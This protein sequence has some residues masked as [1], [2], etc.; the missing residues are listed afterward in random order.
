MID[1]G[2]DSSASLQTLRFFSVAEIE[3]AQTLVH[4]LGP[5]IETQP[6]FLLQFFLY[7]REGGF[8][9]LAEDQ[10]VDPFAAKF[11]ERT[12]RGDGIVVGG[13]TVER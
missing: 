11:A 5:R 13:V 9:A 8:S 3:S 12:G 10:V 1:S 7:C 4:C 6:K 2:D